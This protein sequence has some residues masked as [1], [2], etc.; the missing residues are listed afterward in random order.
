[1]PD[2]ILQNG[3]VVQ[4]N[5]QPE[6]IDRLR[7]IG[8]PAD[9]N[10]AEAQSWRRFVPG[11][12]PWPKVAEFEE[13]VVRLEQLVSEVHAEMLVLV[14][15]RQ[16]APNADTEALAQ[17]EIN[18]AVGTRPEPTAPKLDAKIASAQER[19]QG[20]HKAIE[21]VTSDRAEYVSRN[22]DKLVKDAH[23][24]V[25]AAQTKATRLLAEFEEARQELIEARR[26]EAWA[27][28][29]P[30]AEARR[31]PNYIA[32]GGGL[33]RILEPLGV[34][35]IVTMTQVLTA[36]RDDVEWASTAL[37]PEQRALTG[38]THRPTAGQPHLNPRRD[39]AIEAEY[40]A[41]KV[42]RDAS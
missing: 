40:Q 16:Q 34:Q 22:R 6:H 21:K 13:H 17:W 20:L 9:L 12:T 18:G 35:Q 27:Q 36:L 1:M 38:E 7:G 2:G 37:T 19:I 33:R 41:A 10:A 3:R 30:A 29:Y 4:V 28:L 15:Q 39:A 24:G 26:T 42:L 8:L 5:D 14:E 31:E 25:E 32:L 23:R 11:R